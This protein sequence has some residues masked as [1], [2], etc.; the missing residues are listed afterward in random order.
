MRLKEYRLVYPLVLNVFLLRAFGKS[1]GHE[2]IPFGQNRH[3][4]SENS[5]KII[6]RIQL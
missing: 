4:E 6:T 2:I 1:Y 5:L 3:P